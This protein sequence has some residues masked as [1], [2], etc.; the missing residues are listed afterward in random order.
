MTKKKICCILSFHDKAVQYEW[1][2]EKALADNLD[3]SFLF[4]N[5]GDS[6]I[7]T[8]MREKKIPCH[9]IYYRGKNDFPAA[10]IKTVN[11]LRKNKISVVHTHLF[12][13]N[14]VGLTAAR[15]CRIKKRIYTRH[16]S[17][18]HH[19]YFPSTI[20]YDKY[21][22]RLATDI[23]A[24]S[25]VVKKV[26]IQKEKVSPSKIHLIHHGFK[27]DCFDD[28]EKE[29]ILNLNQKYN[30]QNRHPVV[31]V[32]SRYIEGKGLQF[33]IPAFK[34]LLDDFPN[35]YLLLA[36]TN[37]IYE[38]EIRKMLQTIPLK[39][40]FEVP[41][42]NDIFALYKLFDVFVHAPVYKEFEAFGQ[43][44]VEALAAGVP[45]VFT[46]SGVANE[47][48]VHNKNAMVAEYSSSDSIYRNM[49]IILERN[50]IKD[51]LIDNGRKSVEHIFN[52]DTFYDQ[53][54]S[55]YL[56]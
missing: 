39:N 42:E 50:D 15:L 27:M 11:Y 7:E 30:P 56:H 29:R 47:F 54:K 43:I 26:L 16:H 13:A 36:N 20:K 25:E 44:Y 33:I 55:L 10:I 22:N 6:F 51:Q 14:M 49:K 12:D 4:L 32:I 24:V 23:I 46:L 53:L 18:Y 35:A 3:L 31:G 2:A 34:K 8:H 45:S 5:P 37:G 19:N 40:Y 21:C 38:A 52:L 48:I 1:V 9:R 17:D 28:I 41:F